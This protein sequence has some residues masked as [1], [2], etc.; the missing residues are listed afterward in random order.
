MT[1]H[2]AFTLALG[3]LLAAAHAHAATLIVANKAEA[4]VSLVDLASGKV[5]AT[6]PVG[7]GPHEV[8]VSPDG[9]LALIANYGT[10]VDISAPGDN[11]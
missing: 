7:T 11:I 5:A 2:T 6:L 3:M 4:S 10:G 1:N 9:R 8:A